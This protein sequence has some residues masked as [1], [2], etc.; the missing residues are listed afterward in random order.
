M[1][2]VTIIQGTN[3]V[4]YFVGKSSP[5]FYTDKPVTPYLSILCMIA[6]PQPGSHSVMVESQQKRDIFSVVNTKHRYRVCEKK[7][8]EKYI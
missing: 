7:P 3:S 6:R 2:N 8:Q 4:R 5:Y 1:L